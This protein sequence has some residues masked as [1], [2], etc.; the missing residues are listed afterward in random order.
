MGFLSRLSRLLSHP[1]R[2]IVHQPS[3]HWLSA[4]FRETS[5]NSFRALG[6]SRTLPTAKK[7]YAA[8]VPKRPF[9]NEIP[10]VYRSLPCHFNSRN[11]RTTSFGVSR[12]QDLSAPSPAPFVKETA[13]SPTHERTPEFLTAAVAVNYIFLSL[14]SYFSLL[15]YIKV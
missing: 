4:A 15:Q 10:L 7:R 1:T 13:A 5:T 11:D 2:L 8:I 14:F 9:V 6:S 12:L 3:S